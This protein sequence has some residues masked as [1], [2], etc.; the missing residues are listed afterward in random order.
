MKKFI[1]AFVTTIGEDKISQF[2]ESLVRP[3]VLHENLESAYMEMAADE[4][5]EQNAKERSEGL[6]NDMTFLS[7]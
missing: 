2:I 6:M 1:K 7:L 4:K 3:H 5:R